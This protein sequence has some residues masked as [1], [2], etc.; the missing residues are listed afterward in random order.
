MQWNK[1]E[2]FLREESRGSTELKQ[3]AFNGKARDLNKAR[4]ELRMAA[5]I[6]TQEMTG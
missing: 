5:L 6:T 3:S 2:I 1:V 4:N